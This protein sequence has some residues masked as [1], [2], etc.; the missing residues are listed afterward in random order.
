MIEQRHRAFRVKAISFVWYRKIKDSARLEHSEH[1]EHSADRVLAMFDEVVGYHEV[2]RACRDCVKP[3]AV[4]YYVY[5]DQVLILQLR[6]VLSE[7]VCRKPVNI[8]D[9]RRARD[10]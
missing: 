8:L 2:E 1:T 6:V 10:I 3:L 7:V 4:I 9:C 5:A